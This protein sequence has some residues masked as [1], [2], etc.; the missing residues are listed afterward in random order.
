LAVEGSLALPRLAPT[1]GRARAVAARN[2]AGRLRGLPVPDGQ[3]R[4]AS[5]RA[6]CPEG[7]TVGLGTVV[8]ALSIGPLLQFLLPA[9]TIREPVPAPA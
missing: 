6:R 2:H 4:R 7:G 5:A 3:T 9:C 8:Y 1:A